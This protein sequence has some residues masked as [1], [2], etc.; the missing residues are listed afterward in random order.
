MK[1]WYASKNYYNIMETPT[2]FARIRQ[3]ISR[4]LC[5]RYYAH[6]DIAKYLDLQMKVDTQTRGPY[7]HIVL[8]H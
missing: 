8:Q 4:N 1:Y 2:F 6:T 7:K 3:R 5:R